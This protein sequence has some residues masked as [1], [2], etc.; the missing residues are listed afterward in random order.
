MKLNADIIYDNLCQT[1]ELERTKKG[2]KKLLLGRPEF[3][4]AGDSKFLED[5]VYITSVECLPSR[6]EFPN[7]MLLICVGKYLPAEYQRARECIRIKGEEDLF[8]VFNRVQKIFDYY[9]EWDS[10][11]KNL[12][13]STADIQEMVEESFSVFGN[14]MVV[15][16]KDYYFYAYS[17]IIDTNVELKIYRP[18][19]HNRY[20]YNR[21]ALS[22]EDEK[23]NRNET[24]PYIVVND[25]TVH[26]SIN[27]FVKKV[28]VGNLKIPFVL[29]SFRNS[30]EALGCYFAGL[31]EKAIQ[32]NTKLM[33][34]YVNPLIGVFRDMLNGIAFNENL[35][36]YLYENSEKKNYICLK[37]ARS[38]RIR[39]K[40]SI[41][42]ILNSITE[43]FDHCAAFE[44]DDYIVAFVYWDEDQTERNWFQDRLKEL[45]K[46]LELKVGASGVFTELPMARLYYRQASIA[47]HTCC[48]RKNKERWCCF[49]DLKLEYMCSNSQGEF[50]LECLMTR[51]FRKLMEHD[52]E[53]KTSYVETLRCYLYNNMNMAKTAQQMFVHRSTFLERIKRIEKILGMDLQDP[54]QRL[55][56]M[57]ILKIME[58]QDKARKELD[59]A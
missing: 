56:V 31:L 2:S 36:H 11:M 46:E 13:E 38:S 34:G 58:M 26:F 16:D 18:N 15:I 4:R 3:F 23:L 51:G 6:P 41:S 8:S 29:R 5:H 42:Y 33:D 55:Y 54:D 53:G 32:K 44:K 57:M 12:L 59:M 9:E 14:P 19:R 40:T 37:F 52:E 28:Y 10:Q 50:P 30:D 35:K 39:A 21:L 22:V 24:R 7:N 43:L 25:G 47:L 45:L 49:E 48:S 17:S 1:L 27:L 20:D